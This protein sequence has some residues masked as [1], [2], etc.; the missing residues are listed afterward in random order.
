MMTT[1]PGH[2]GAHDFT[3]QIRVTGEQLAERVRELIHE[4]NVQ[5]LVIRHDAHVIMEIP[6]NVG[7]V[8]ALLAPMLAAV[9]AAGALLTHCTIEVV[10]TKPPTP[11][12]PPSPEI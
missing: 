3:E 7:V 1:P 6:M 9:G 4:G 2:S 11:P 12:V 8:G 10:R 5:H